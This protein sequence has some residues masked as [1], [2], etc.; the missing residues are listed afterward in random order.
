MGVGF[1]LPGGPE[2]AGSGGKRLPPSWGPRDSR[3]QVGVGFPLP[4]G[5][6]TAGLRWEPASPFLGAPRQPGSGGRRL[7]P[8]LLA[9]LG[10]CSF[11]ISKDRTHEGSTHNLMTHRE[12]GPSLE[13]NTAW[14]QEK[15]RGGRRNA[16]FCVQPEQRSGRATPW[17]ALMP[18]RMQALDAQTTGRGRWPQANP[19]GP[20][21]KQQTLL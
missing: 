12:K 5:P 6:E 18:T 11:H 7:P 9:P 4:G 14:S 2:T 19:A 21:T 3:A 15:K 1:P 17:Q 13:K 16:V 10:W 8:S 20:S